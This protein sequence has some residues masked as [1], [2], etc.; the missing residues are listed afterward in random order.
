MKVKNILKKLAFVAVIA[1]TVNGLYAQR[2]DL[3]DKKWYL[4][5]NKSGREYF[6][7]NSDGSFQSEINGKT[8]VGKWE[9]IEAK[10]ELHLSGKSKNAQIF[11]VEKASFGELILTDGRKK[12]KYIIKTEM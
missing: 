8:D 5:S 12:L 9:Y 3:T 10:K 7:L 2:S 1:F 4:E 11:S 6:T